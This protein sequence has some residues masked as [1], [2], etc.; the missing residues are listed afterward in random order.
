MS[1][2]REL[3]KAYVPADFESGIYQRWLAAD[4]FAPDGKGSR[5]DTSKAPFVI[6]QPPPNITGSLHPGAGPADGG[7]G[8]AHPPRPDAW[9]SDPVPARPRPC[10]DRRA[11]RPRQDHRRGGP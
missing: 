3:P 8:P 7:R 9:P 6:I 11:V 5:A 1:E 10:L 2:P 4:V